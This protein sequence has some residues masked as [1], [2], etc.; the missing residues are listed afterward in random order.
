MNEE[1][2]LEDVLIILRRR[3]L[4]FLAPIITIVPIGLVIIML[5]PPRYTAFGKI[6]IDSQ[7]IPQAWVQSTV[8]SYA[9]ERIQKIKQQVL[10][11]SLLLEIAEKYQ[12]FPKESGLTQ[13]ERVQRMRSALDVNIIRSNSRQK[14]NADNTIAFTVAFTDRSPSKAYQVANEFMTLFLSEDVR[15]RTESA[16]TAT[17]FFTQEST[18]LASLIDQTEARIA[19]YKAKNSDALPADLNLHQQSLLRA[20][21]DLANTQSQI[22]I[23]EEDLSS[24]QTQIATYLSGSAGQ[25]GPAQQLAQLRTQLATL[26][27]EKTDSHPDVI[28]AKEQI[29]ALQ[30]QLQPSPA[31]RKLRADLADADQALRAA[32]AKDAPDE[33]EITLLRK[34]S[35]EIREQLSAQFAREAS[36]GSSDLVLAQMQSRMDMDSNRLEQLEDQ[37]TDLKKRIADLQDAI[38]RTPTVERGLAAL[39]RDY[40]NIVNQY[41]ALKSKQSAAVLS[42]NLEGDQK[43]EKFSILESAQRPD[44]PT[45]PNRPQLAFLLIVA[46]IAI[47]AAFAFLIELLFSSLRGRHHVTALAGEPPIAVIPYFAAENARRGA[48][49]FM[50]KPKT[51]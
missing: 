24:V 42:E 44:K 41:D 13:S 7:Q 21:Q 22:S 33:A 29:R 17:E 46:S 34:Q 19:D 45:K 49:A 15:T 26:R 23:T 25:S 28:A 39:T 11:R 3:M 14:R 32:R 38:A 20:Q 8:N 6:L 5:L 48:L 37:E 43:A 1:F 27:T 47:G 10:T 4:Y 30:S 50:R 18:R 9:E 40:Q 2:S 36:S 31:I 35:A 16:S 51:A 12:L